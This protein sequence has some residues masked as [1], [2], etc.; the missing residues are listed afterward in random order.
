MIGWIIVGIIAGLLGR[1]LVP[2][3][4]PL[5]FLLTLGLG[6]AGS[7]VGGFLSSLLFGVDPRDSTIHP[8][9]IIMSTIGAVIL[10]MGYISL[11]RRQIG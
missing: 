11:K 3:R 6:M 5:G 4:Q 1:L 9:G 8:S 2:G 10:L 7:L